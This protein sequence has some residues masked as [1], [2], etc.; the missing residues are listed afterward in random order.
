MNP[1]NSLKCLQGAWSGHKKGAC[2]CY[3]GWGDLYQYVLG[4]SRNTRFRVG[5]FQGDSYI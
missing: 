3:S 4:S 2:S 1:T 5:G